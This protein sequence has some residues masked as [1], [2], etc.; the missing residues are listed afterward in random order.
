M[1]DIIFL[2]ILILSITG[3][4]IIITSKF[5][6]L[7]TIDTSI[8]TKEIQDKQKKELLRKRLERKMRGLIS[9]KEKKEN[10]LQKK[11]NSIND[12]IKK[13]ETID[14]NNFIKK[15]SDEPEKKIFYMEELSKKIEENINNKEYS[16]AEDLCYQYLKLEKDNLFIL[17]QIALIYFQTDSYDKSIETY[18]Y[19]ITLLKKGKTKANSKENDQKIV[20]F[21]IKIADIYL[22]NSNYKK[23]ISV[24]DSAFLIDKNNPKILDLLIESYIELKDKFMAKKILKKMEEA[25][26]ENLKIPEFKDRIEKM[27]K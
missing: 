2:I 3:A 5:T 26:S 24:L 19:I 17:E 11:Q 15:I 9:K 12:T 27:F 10:L 8:I 21:L 25:N 23:I 16:I 13:Y 20:K 1:T 18:E 22:L 7:K 6:Q 4:S 14:E